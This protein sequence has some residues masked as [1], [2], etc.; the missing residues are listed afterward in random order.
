MPLYEYECSS[1]G[2]RLER[3]QRFDEAPLRE[4]PACG[5]ILAR[6]LQPVGII[7]KGPGFYSTDHRPSAASSTETPGSDSA[8]SRSDRPGGPAEKSEQTGSAA[9]S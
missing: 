2:G 6:L 9:R 7:F 4:C 1:C 8:S 5:G 3:R